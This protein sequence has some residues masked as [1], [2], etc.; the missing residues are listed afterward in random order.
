MGGVL[1]RLTGAL[2]YVPDAQTLKLGGSWM[3]H[4]VRTLFAER[5]DPEYPP[6]D[7]GWV[8]T[9]LE[10][11]WNGTAHELTVGLEFKGGALGG[12]DRHRYALQAFVH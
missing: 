10:R 2:G 5:Y 11:G 9:G 1:S 3:S 4:H 6:E 8:V 12:R 7:H